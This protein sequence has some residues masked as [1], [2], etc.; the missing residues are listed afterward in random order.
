MDRPAAAAVSQGTN[1][2]F[3]VVLPSSVSL[4]FL[5]T[6]R[7]VLGTPGHFFST[8]PAVSVQVSVRFGFISAFVGILGTALK[9]WLTPRHYE[10]LEGLGQCV[11]KQQMAFDESLRPWLLARIPMSPVLAM[12]LVYGLIHVFHLMARAMGTEKA[13]QEGARYLGFAFAPLAVAALPL[14]PFWVCF[15]WS[16]FLALIALREGY[17]LGGWLA[18]GMVSFVFWSWMAV[19][20]LMAAHVVLP[21]LP[22][23]TSA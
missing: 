19:E 22:Q 4:G 14:M 8:L 12:V 11:V 20:F 7:L 18:W 10:A 21:C 2:R 6:L 5:A 13:L 3:A 1:A 15:V 17:G 9:D 23:L 16:L